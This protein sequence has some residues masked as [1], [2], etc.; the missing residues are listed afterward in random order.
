MGRPFVMA[1]ATLVTAG[2]CGDVPSAFTAS[3]SRICWAD[4][5]VRGQ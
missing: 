2:S 1:R 3:T 5:V 4:E